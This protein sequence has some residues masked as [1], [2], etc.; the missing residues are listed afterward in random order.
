MI[1]DMPSNRKRNSIV[2]ELFIR[3]RK[4]NIS[5]VFV[6]QSYF[7]VP[8]NMRLNSTHYFVMKISKQR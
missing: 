5:L 2:S 1:S 4:L 7:V 8:E 6:T 3:V